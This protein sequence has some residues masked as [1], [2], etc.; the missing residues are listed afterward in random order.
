[1]PH[2]DRP[3]RQSATS[4][5]PARRRWAAAVVVAVALVALP[6]AGLA[7]TTC[8]YQPRTVTVQM[9]AGEAA[10]LSVGGQGEIL[11][12]GLT[13]PDE[14]DVDSP[15]R[16]ATVDITGA[17]AVNGT[18]TADQVVI[19]QTSA[20]GAF[21]G[22][23]SFVLDLRF[24]ADDRLRVVGTSGNDTL[25]AVASTL[26]LVGPLDG[27]VQLGGVDAVEV[28]VG[29]GDDVVQ[30]DREDVDS[31]DFSIPITIRGGEGNDVLTGGAGN[32][33]VYGQ[34]GNDLLDGFDGTDFLNGGDGTDQC[35]LVDALLSCDPEIGLTP[36]EGTDETAV[37]A[38]GTGWYP[39]N[40]D[41]AIRFGEAEP[42]LSVRAGQDGSFTTSDLDV[43]PAVDD[44]TSVT[45]TACQGCAD[46]EPVLATTEFAYTAVPGELTL[47]VTPD[48]VPIGQPVAVS[49][50]G[51]IAGEPVS[52][53]VDG[54][55]VDAEPAPVADGDGLFGASF[56]LEDA[57]LGEHRLR[58][59]QRCETDGE[60][61]MEI[62]FAIEA[63]DQVPIIQVE[64]DTASVGD[65]IRVVG[66]GFDRELG[67]VHLSIDSAAAEEQKLAAFRP[68]RNGEFD[69]TFTV[70]DAAD[71][72]YTVR[73]CQRCASQ[74]PN[75][76][77]D[78]L[79]IG[80]APPPIPWILVG[81]ALLLV[82][83]TILLV[84]RWRRIRR[85][86]R[87][88]TKPRVRAGARPTPPEVTVTSSAC[89][90]GPWT[91]GSGSC[92]ARIAGPNEWRR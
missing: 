13:C 2:Q 84:R 35:R 85:D 83:G 33:R 5:R 52:L 40:D 71:G 37:V 54:A 21:P 50:S 1:M 75:E 51:W 92:P 41:V 70:P 60:R 14:T 22:F 63:I 58:A 46:A 48:P 81:V 12:N 11:V 23:L 86:R 68:D 87:R 80:S 49:G 16:V 6:R 82:V 27:D 45:V 55:P 57:A 79:A 8:S 76:A 59:C 7:Q 3:S 28:D 18:D 78:E 38:T 90:T 66:A 47:E 91:T 73:A 17:I 69:I 89:R 4:A 34:G 74:N 44:A 77:T 32:D 42:Q 10:T 43:P 30:A 25:S 56:E 9:V 19:D 39:E 88:L 72:S 29:V 64:P 24:D 31:P 62:V 53:F 26:H 61:S 36:S 65:D 15:S 20:G 67:R